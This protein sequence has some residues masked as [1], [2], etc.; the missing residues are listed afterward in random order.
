M[1]E[2]KQYKILVFGPQASGKG[3][4]VEFLSKELNI[5]IFSMGSSLR[6]RAEIDDELGQEIKSLIDKGIFAPD[7]VVARII[8]EKIEKEGQNGYILDGYPRSLIQ[9]EF[10]N[11][12]EKL[13]H[14]LE[15]YI[16]DDEAI[17]RVTGRRT[18]TKCE[19]IY[20]TEFLKPKQ[21]GFCDKCG[22]QLVVR[23]DESE[24]TLKIRLNTYHKTTEPLVDYYTNQGI[25]IKIN[26]E[27][28]IED[29]KKEIFKKLNLS[30]SAL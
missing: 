24:E 18:C 6:Q 19:T 4:Q 8:M 2:N 13:T 21:E 23:E 1:S 7:D 30:S 22:G 3:T 11:N 26:G 5:P 16:S 17:R 20:H 9:A 27:Q 28:S 25:L 12:K 10:F 15:I 29:V 14:V